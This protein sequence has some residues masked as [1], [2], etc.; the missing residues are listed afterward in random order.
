MP[1]PQCAW[2][3]LLLCA[4]P[5]MVHALRTIPPSQAAEFA[6][7]HDAA[8]QECLQR[9]LG[10]AIPELSQEIA[11]LPFREG[12]LGLQ[13]ARRTSPAAY[14]A[15]WAD[16][17]SQVHRRLP[18]VCT[19]I[20]VE[21]GTGVHSAAASVREAA[22]AVE[23]LSAD[24]FEAPA[25]DKF[26]DPDFRA[27]QP[28]GQQPG[29]WRHGWQF[30]AC[31]ARDHHFAVHVHL[32]ALTP[33]LRALR[34]SQCGPCASR[35]FTALPT[36]PETVLNPAHFRTLLLVRLM[37]PLHLDERFC[38]CG[39]RLDALGR[40][41]SACAKVGIL[42]ARGAPAE[43]CA[44]RIC[45][46]AG[47][48]VRENQLLRDLNVEV[49]AGD[50]RK[51]EVIANGLSLWGGRQL[52]VDTTVVSALTGRGCARGATAGTAL[53]E[54]RRAKERRYP[55]LVS[56][57]RCK[58]VV[59]GFEVAGRWSAEASDFLQL[60]ARHKAQACP[61]LLRRSTA[62]LFFQRWT[63]MLACSV[64]RAYA[65]SLLGEPLAGKACVNGDLVPVAAL[66][67]QM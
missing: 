31:A 53:K 16:C 48:R 65:A 14:W 45:R 2:L 18:A 15:S 19:Q 40:H 51:I 46:E 30:H 60:L 35:H 24:G 39:A 26:C 20:L 33:D 23:Q 13:S 62:A 43:V 55:E 47:A 34:H 6:T 57:D 7:T 37:M 25:W 54:A 11:A 1:D 32:P 36:T 52:A 67:R 27:P 38:K 56:A 66:D 41:R 4:G 3:L 49:P 22:Q 58:L 17:L 9:I 28:E 64:Q 50:T 42:A 59:L 5:R 61:C 12:G 10:T 63:G 44:A 8:M 29:E 21:L